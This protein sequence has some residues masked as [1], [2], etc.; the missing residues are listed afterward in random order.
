[1]RN[2]SL[3]GSSRHDY[4]S[5]A[6]APRPKYSQRPSPVSQTSVASVI[7]TF[8]ASICQLGRSSLDDVQSELVTAILEVVFVT[9]N[10]AGV[11]TRKMLKLSN[12]EP[13]IRVD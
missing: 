5:D 2:Q 3:K 12:E 10:S 8:L 13:R 11:A 1:M 6:A 9:M 7:D 4:V